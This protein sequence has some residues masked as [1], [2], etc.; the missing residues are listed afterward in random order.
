MKVRYPIEAFALAMVVFSQNMRDALIT[1]IL[2]LFIT[3]LGLLLDQLLGSKLPRWSRNSCNIIL[4]VSITHS[5]FQIVLIAVLGY[6]VQDTAYIFHIFLGI[7]IAKHIIDAEGQSNYNRLLL[8]GA[9]AYAT[10]LIISIIREFMADGAIYGY[11]ITDFTYKSYGF[12]L[13]TMGFI[14][15]GIGIAILNR[16]FY[17]DIDIIRSEA[18]LVIIPVIFVV[19]PFVIDSIDPSISMVITIAI[20]LILFYSIRKYLVF[21]RLSK[22]IKKL[23]VEILSMGMI[24]IILSMF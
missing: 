13:V 22:E 3:T 19:Q 17:K 8:E 5:L 4:M 15:T 1:G 20:G 10:L 23:P 6:E 2:I 24:Y 11:E 9:G 21:S 18:L 7:L 16:V 14:L 12:S